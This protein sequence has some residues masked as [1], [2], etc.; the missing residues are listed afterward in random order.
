MS[1]NKENGLNVSKEQMMEE[2]EEN[3]KKIETEPIEKTGTAWRCKFY[4]HTKS[5]SI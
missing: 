4:L 5:H 2:N 1:D 3:T